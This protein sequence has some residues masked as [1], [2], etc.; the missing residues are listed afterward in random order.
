MG[1]SMSDMLRMPEILLPGDV[2]LTRGKGLFDFMIRWGQGLARR[3]WH[4][5][6]YSHAAL[7]SGPLSVIDA[8]PG[9]RIGVRPLK[10]WIQ[11]IEFD[12][13]I[14]FRSPVNIVMCDEMLKAI[15][16]GE[17]T[18]IDI[19]PP[20]AS[21]SIFRAIRYYSGRSYNWLFL[22]AKPEGCARKDFFCSEYV[23]A[24]LSRLDANVSFAR[25]ESV[26]P[27]DLPQILE[28]AGWTKRA[29]K[30][31]VPGWGVGDIGNI[32]DKLLDK[33]VIMDIE[34]EG[35]ALDTID[36]T[37]NI[38]A[39]LENLHATF[40]QCLYGVEYRRRTIKTER[41]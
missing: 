29:L 22:V 7:C 23:I 28:G 33:N 3:Q 36:V 30:D 15:N 39:G 26:L 11:D 40:A 6:P 32:V 4:L 8:N 20:S 31:L 16:M 18:K 1:R 27:I 19:P 13:A 34:S 41:N 38:I 5:S 2:V 24:A 9:Q 14:V 12:K 17:G 10:A 25:P 37:K 21:D 35:I